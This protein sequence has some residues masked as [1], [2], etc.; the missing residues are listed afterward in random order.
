MD[1]RHVHLGNRESYSQTEEETAR[2]YAELSREGVQMSEAVIW[3]GSHLH[4]REDGTG[5]L[6]GAIPRRPRFLC[7]VFHWIGGMR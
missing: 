1:L 7:Q 6:E 2:L 3:L 4:I 5:W